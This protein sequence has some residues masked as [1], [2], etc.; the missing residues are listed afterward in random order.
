MPSKRRIVSGEELRSSVQGY[1]NDPTD[2]KVLARLTTARYKYIKKNGRSKLNSFTYYA[3][4][5]EPV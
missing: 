4:Y 3:I 5:T 1:E 2:T